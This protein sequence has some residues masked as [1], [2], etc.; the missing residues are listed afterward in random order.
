MMPVKNKLAQLVKSESQISQLQQDYDTGVA[1]ATAAHKA[2][3]EASKIII[4]N[5]KQMLNDFE[6]KTA[7]LSLQVENLKRQLSDQAKRHQARVTELKEHIERQAQQLLPV[8][9]SIESSIHH[10]GFWVKNWWT[11]WKWLST[12]AFAAIAYISIAGIPP[13]V[14]ALIPE[15]SQGKVTALLALLGFVGRFV[16]QNRAKALPPVVDEN[17]HSA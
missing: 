12:W 5:K 9:T 3:E 8:I 4:Q 15:A 16:N 2:N 14:M 11:W 6:N 1:D 10:T 13:E 17:D 7:D